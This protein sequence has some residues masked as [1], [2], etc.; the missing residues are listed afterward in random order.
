MVLTTIKIFQRDIFAGTHNIT[1]LSNIVTEQS[2]NTSS[3]ALEQSKPS[4]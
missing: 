4:T 2:T 3:D 1:Q